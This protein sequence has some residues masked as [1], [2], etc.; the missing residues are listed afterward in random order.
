MKY[1]VFVKSFKLCFLVKLIKYFSILYTEKETR[2][3]L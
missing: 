3:H 1:D 2:D